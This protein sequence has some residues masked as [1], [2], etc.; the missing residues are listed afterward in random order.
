MSKMY[1]AL[2]YAYAEHE[3]K[4]TPK[5]LPPIF[6]EQTLKRQTTI[7]LPVLKT[8]PKISPDVVVDISGSSIEPEMLRLKQSI[9]DQLP[10]PQKNILQF[11]GSQQGVG[12]STIVREFG[13]I[14]DKQHGK[15]VL[16][17]DTDQ[18]HHGSQHQAF[19]IHPK[20]PLDGFMK[21]GGSLETAISQVPHSRIFL[22][23]LAEKKASNTKTSRL[24]R[25]ELMWEPVRKE[26]DFI[27]IDSPS[28]NTSSDGLAVSATVDGVIIVV[29][30]EKTRFPVT[31]SMTDRITKSGGHILG[32]AFN[33]QHHYIPDWVYRWL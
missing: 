22:S 26:F 19:G 16:L 33:K 15:S 29:E 20:N 8:I 5:V 32:M 21:N 9:L 10:D 18:Q 27:L 17:I 23:L 28:I 25:H 24:T 1:E 11:I 2:Q 4:H 12:T 3:L 6:S 30:A 31:H 14:L 7:D 13:K